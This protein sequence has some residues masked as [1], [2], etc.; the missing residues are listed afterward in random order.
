MNDADAA[1]KAA[2]F[3]TNPSTLLDGPNGPRSADE[4]AA[5]VQT[6]VASYPPA[7]PAVLGILKDLTSK[8][9]STDAIQKAIGTGLGK[10]ANVCK[11]TDLTFSLE[12]QGEL[13]ATGSTDAN[14]QYAA[15]TGNDPTRSVALSGAT[16][17]SGGGSGGQTT[18]LGGAAS[19]SSPL[20][21]F[22]ANSVSNKPTNFFTS[23][24]S[25]GGSLPATTTT[26]TPITIIVCTVSRSC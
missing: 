24:T 15:L 3:T 7:L 19:F 5:D 21:T 25:G 12:I 11:T 6:F 13:G 26:N 18:P 8:G 17:G 9:T 20:Q 16:T 23:S 4:I 2:S 10:A 22:V 1:Q 14:A